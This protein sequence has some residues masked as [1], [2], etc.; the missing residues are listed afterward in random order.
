MTKMSRAHFILIANT[1]KLLPSFTTSQSED[2]VRFDAICS[3]FADAL[4][5]TNPLF[6]RERFLS[7]CKGGSN[8]EPLQSRINPESIRRSCW[9]Y[10]DASSSG[11]DHIQPE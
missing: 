10:L 6:K 5:P 3:R 1:I 9:A 7:A 8:G 11:G 4:S 2:V